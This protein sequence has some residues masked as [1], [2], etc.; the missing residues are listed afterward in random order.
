MRVD[1]ALRHAGRSRC[2]KELK[3]RGVRAVTPLTPCLRLTMAL[4]AGCVRTPFAMFRRI[5][6]LAVASV[7]LA[8]DQP[9]SNCNVSPPPPQCLTNTAMEGIAARLERRTSFTVRT[10]PL[11]C[12]N[13]S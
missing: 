5:V 1:R 7:A 4:C 3:R 11:H 12:G 8:Q 13:A 10:W 9:K 2:D 6:I